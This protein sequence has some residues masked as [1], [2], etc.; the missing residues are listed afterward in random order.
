MSDAVGQIAAA[1]V[2]PLAITTA[3]RSPHTPNVPTLIES[4]LVEF[5]IESWNA[6]LA[7]AGTPQPIVDRLADVMAQMAK[8][9]TVQKRMADFGSIAVAN[10]PKEFAAFLAAE[11]EKFSA[12][13]KATGIK[14][15]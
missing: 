3:K 1:T 9:A 7:P 15:E 2:R 8:D 11:N 6:L 10:S 13:V 14:A 12:L 5:P 4:G